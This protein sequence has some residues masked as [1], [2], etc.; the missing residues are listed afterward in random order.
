MDEAMKKELKF[1]VKGTW[2]K[3]ASE[4]TKAIDIPA[5]VLEQTPEGVIYIFTFKSITRGWKNLSGRTATIFPSD[6][7]PYE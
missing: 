5:V 2:H 7:T 3:P 1:G 6:F 4:R